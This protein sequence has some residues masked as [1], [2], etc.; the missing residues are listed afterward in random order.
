QAASG[1]AESDRQQGAGRE[2][3]PGSV[4]AAHPPGAPAALPVIVSAAVI[5]TP[6]ASIDASPAWCR[7]CA[8]GEGSGHDD[9]LAHR[10]A[11]LDDGQCLAGLVQ[12]VLPTD[13][14]SDDLVSDDRGDLLE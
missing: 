5:A 13:P 10:V 14:R 12:R 1:A 6:V 8:S 9:G 7:G 3:H 11:R 4:A 2:R